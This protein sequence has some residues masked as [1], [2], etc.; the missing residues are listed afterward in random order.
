MKKDD[1][2]KTEQR[3]D[4]KGGV[5]KE[6]QIEIAKQ[7]HE[8]AEFRYKNLVRRGQVWDMPRENLDRER[9]RA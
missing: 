1:R 7:N 6:V 5:P 2:H 3:P 8:L 9:N 4:S